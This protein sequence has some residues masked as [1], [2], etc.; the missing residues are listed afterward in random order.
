MKFVGVDGCSEG[1]FAVLILNEQDWSFGIFSDIKSLWEK[2]QD[3]SLILIDIPIGLPFSKNR[4]CDIEARRILKKR[5]SSVFPAPA[6]EAIH[7]R[8][9]EEACQINQKILGKKISLQTWHISHKIWE[10]DDLLILDGKVRNCL[11]ESHPEVCFW[12]L[13]GGQAMSY[14]K[15]A[16]RGISERLAVLSKLFPNSEE[17]FRS[18]SSE[19]KRSDLAK[20]DILDAIALAI[21][22]SSL[23][24]TLKTLPEFPDRD[25][26]HLPIEIVYSN[27]YL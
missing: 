24:E 3:S 12:A 9:Y 16:S 27:R 23:P 4:L 17:I 18:A 1:W 14:S 11:R 6:R 15:K 26:E 20:D 25:R 8:N 22:A 19:F 2:N 13:A 7:A 5:G 21:T 10:V